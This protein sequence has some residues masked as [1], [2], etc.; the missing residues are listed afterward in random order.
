MRI[1]S[2]VLSFVLLILFSS[3]SFACWGF[4]AM[5][6]GGVFVAV[7]DDANIAYWNRAGAGQMDNWKDG[8]KQ[9]ILTSTVLDNIGF[10]NRKDFSRSPYYD[11]VN[12][13][14]KINQ[15]F[16]WTIAATWNGGQGY[17]FSPGLGFRL[18]GGGELDKMSVGIGYY[19]WN[20]EFINNIRLRQ[21]M[22][23]IHLDYLY[24]ITSEFNFGIHIER[25]WELSAV[26]TSPDAAGSI[27]THGKIAESMNFRPGIAWMPQGNLKG[28][29]V[30][31]GIYDMFAQGGGPHYSFGFEFT[32]QAE[33]KK[34]VT[35]KG[36]DKKI[37][38][39]EDDKAWLQNSHF[40]AGIY[41][42][43]GAAG[44]QASAV[45][46]GY[47]YDLN[48]DIEIGGNGYFGFADASGGWSLA[49]GVAWKN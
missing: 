4:R 18:P 14:Q 16:G 34:V 40:R 22:Q 47:G 43:L 45:M 7:A 21:L 36:K 29:I 37:K 38:Y 19:L 10:F 12:F 15:N 35:G 23:Q 48:K 2:F 44:E 1:F 46:I 32:P 13:A 39:V 17:V 27:T 8:E 28:L 33:F 20:Y 11:S 30:N 31:A 49:G 24:K 5:G 25:F 41:N 3:V 26:L 42:M 9:F 6:M